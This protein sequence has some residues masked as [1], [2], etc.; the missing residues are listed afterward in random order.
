M[1]TGMSEALHTDGTRGGADTAPVVGRLAPSPSGRM[2]LGNVFAYLM[3]WLSARSAGGSVVLR[4]ENI[5]PRSSRRDLALALIDD[6]KW[7]G[8]EWDGDVVWQDERGPAH[9]DA[10]RVLDEAG[11]LYPCFC[12]RAELHAASAPH[13][14]DGTPLYAG[15]CRSLSAVEIDV[16]TKEFEREGRMPALR[17]R[18]PGVDDPAATIR[19]EDEVFG[20][21]SENLARECGDFLVRRSDGVV[22]YQLA[23]VVDDAA[24]GVNQVVR[25]CDLLGSCARQMYLQ[26]LLGLP[27]PQYLHVPLLVAPDARRLSKRDHDLALDVL[28]ERFAGPEPILGALAS[29]VGMAE[30]GEALSAEDLIGRFSVEELR[31]H[32]DDIVVAEDFLS[33]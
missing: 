22:A 15:T 1:E 23:V 9:T 29:L 33:R 2:H 10:I 4:V 6:L 8:L 16:R 18:V 13:A 30:P 32:R 3:A 17:L 7:L 31:A 26:D 11:L 14:S 27:R 28:R 12:T 20:G 5:D 24:A 25:G 21:F 19:V